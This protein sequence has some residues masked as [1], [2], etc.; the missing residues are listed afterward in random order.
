MTKPLAGCR[1][2]FGALGLVVLLPIGWLLALLAAPAGLLV[3]RRLGDFAWIGLPRRRAVARENL[4]RAFGS[5]TTAAGL[6]HWA[7]SST[8]G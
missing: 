8:L 4:A 5:E 2:L 3:G 7:P 1:S 6:R